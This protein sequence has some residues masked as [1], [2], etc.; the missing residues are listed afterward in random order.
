MTLSVQLIQIPA[1]ETVPRR[2]FFLT[3]D[4][5]K[6]GRDYAADVCLPDL[7]GKIS[8]THLVLRK[9]PDGSYTVRNVSTNG[10]ALNNSDLPKDDSAPI[11]DGD[12]LSF[13]EYRLL[14]GIV[15]GEAVPAGDVQDAEVIF[16]TESDFSSDEALMPGEAMESPA[17]FPEHEFTR[18]EVDLDPDLMFDPF[19]EGPGL[20]EGAAD[21]ARKDMQADAA[22]NAGTPMDIVPAGRTA[23]PTQYGS[24]MHAVLYRE[25]VM[26]AME[27]A[28]ET[29]LNEVD[30]SE[31][32]SD[33]DDFIPMLAS[34]R[35]RYW[36]IHTRQFAKKRSNGDYRRSFMALFAEEMRKR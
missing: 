26:E 13:G 32:Q 19:A 29:F 15:G 18:A 22:G 10:T 9:T 35:K 17:E 25:Q 16:E 12:V 8:R 3:G 14:I 2:E 1:S 5:F 34:R 31:L 11:V 23:M 4:Q 21:R 28:F 24:D 27:R 33:Y 36:K 7:S 6:I 20:D 30:P